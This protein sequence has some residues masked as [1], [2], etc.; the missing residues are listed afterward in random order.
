MSLMGQMGEALQGDKTLKFSYTSGG[1]VN[2]YTLE[3]VDSIN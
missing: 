3:A 2:W 1:S